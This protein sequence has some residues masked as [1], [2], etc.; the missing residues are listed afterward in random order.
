[1]GQSRRFGATRER[2]KMREPG[3][4]EMERKNESARREGGSECVGE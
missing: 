1:M 3:E 2:K 4:A